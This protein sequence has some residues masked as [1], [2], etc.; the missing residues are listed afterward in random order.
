MQYQNE[1]FPSSIKK[2]KYGSKKSSFKR[3]RIRENKSKKN[4]YILNY[5]CNH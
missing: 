1:E 3:C 5:D 4:F 2:S